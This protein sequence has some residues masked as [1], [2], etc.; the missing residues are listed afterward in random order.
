MKIRSIIP[1]RGGSKAIPKKNITLIDGKPLL[2]YTIEASLNSVVGAETYVSSDSEEILSVAEECGAKS[3]RRPAEIA[4]DTSQSEETLLH[5]LESH[6]CDILVFIQATSPFLKAEHLNAG[7]QKLIDN[8]NLNSVFSVF[9]ENWLPLWS[10][11]RTPVDWDIERRPMRQQVPE[12]YV[13]NGAFYISR[14]EAV[15]KHRLRY[16]PPLISLS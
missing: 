15:L 9:R 5:F 10:T 14:T 7:I 1:A 4:T 12:R 2:A 6:P 11:D 13:E 8:P 16:W 3:V